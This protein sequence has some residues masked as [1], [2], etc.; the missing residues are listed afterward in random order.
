MFESLTDLIKPGE[1]ARP[2]DL[3]VGSLCSSFRYWS[4]PVCISAFECWD[5]TGCEPSRILRAAGFLYILKKCA[6]APLLSCL[7]EAEVLSVVAG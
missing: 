1:L 6:A 4:L 2:S 3:F 5:E 7:R